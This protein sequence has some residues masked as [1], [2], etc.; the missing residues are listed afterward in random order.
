MIALSGSCCLR[1]NVHMSF[2]TVTIQLPNM[3]YQRLTQHS[4]AV[5]RPVDEVAADLVTDALP[6]F[7]SVPTA[8]KYELQQMEQFTDDEL[9]Q[10]ARVDVPSSKTEEMQ[11][12]VE[13]RQA[14][15]L[16]RQEHEQAFLLSQYFN[17]LMLIR[18]KAA[19]ILKSRSVDVD[20]LLDVN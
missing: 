12:L 5:Q 18:A 16:T 7:G 19:A 9:W 17:R 20:S 2:Q 8:L 14:E 6:E 15:G 10:V 4:R 1:Y 3:V 13:K 11:W